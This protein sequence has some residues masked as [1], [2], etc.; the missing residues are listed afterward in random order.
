MGVAEGLKKQVPGDEEKS[1]FKLAGLGQ[2]AA[3][4]IEG[5]AEIVAKMWRISEP[6]MKEK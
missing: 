1:R 3:E 2:E 4:R 6:F 5:A